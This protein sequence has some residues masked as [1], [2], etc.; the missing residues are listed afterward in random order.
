MDEEKL[1]LKNP[2]AG[3]NASLMNDDDIIRYWIKPHILFSRQALG[4][5]LTGDIPVVL[6]G[7]RGTGKTMLLKFMSNEVTVKEYVAKHQTGHRFLEKTPYLA[8]YHRFDGPS[9][10]SFVSRHTSEEAWETIF[11]HYLELVIG[12]KFTMML[13]NLKRN[14][15]F[16]LDPS[17]ENELIIGVLKLVDPDCSY[18]VTDCSIEFAT[19]F[20]Q[21]RLDRVFDFI[22]DSAISEGTKFSQH[23]VN[24]G[25]LIFGVP[26]L[27]LKVLPELCGKKIIILLDEYENLRL[28][29]QKIVNTLVKHT[30]LPVTFRIGTRLRGF[31]TYDTL[32]EGE[33]LMEDADY[34]KI[35]FEDVLTAKKDSFRDLLRMIA[36]RRLE[37]IREFGRKQIVDI[38]EILGE[39]SYED[40]ALMIVFG[41]KMSRREVDEYPEEKYRTEA[42]HIQE[43]MD[44]LKT[45]YHSDAEK[46]LSLLIDKQKPLF[47][48]LN[49]LLLRRDYKPD[50]VERLF[51][52]YVGKNKESPYYSK[53]RNLYDKNK[54]D[55]LFQL[56]SL[57]KPRQKQYAGFS[58]FC[59]L[60]SGIIRN[61]LELCYQS[62]NI[63]L[64]S[65][66]E[67]LIEGRQMP[68]QAQTEGAKIRA[69]R[70]MDVIERI[71]EYGNEVKSLVRSLGAIFYSWQNDPV[72]SEPEVTYFCVDSTSLSDK[73]R[74]IL[75]SAAQWSVLQPKKPMKGKS[76][77]D[78]LFDAY[79][80]NHILAPYFGISYRLRGR[81]REFGRADLEALM[82][83]TEE[84]KSKA[85]IRLSRHPFPGRTKTILDFV[86]KG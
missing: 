59:M 8:V 64:F 48:M 43:I 19:A 74:K 82:F 84:E 2:F 25:R 42:K 46:T 80:L 20:L 24:S 28:N 66:R 38:E 67:S 7:G 44:I 21:Q 15:C 86:G 11:K 50:Q 33:F 78:P 40:E 4:V 3:F 85:I 22:N 34:R 55:L 41:R 56:I 83:G 1:D 81:I 71:P 29:Q 17:R 69:E 5:D 60:S 14:R 47:E 37:Q 53:Y 18:Q 73:A 49:L 13:S 23:I 54:V 27:A 16:D 51:K 52:A 58:T 32:N 12:Q 68:I 10:G 75:D 65:D 39:L 57:N 36:R 26:E 63:A 62:F 70:Y 45:K 61:F 79:A 6:E 35:R 31:K 76:A 30:K 9:L 72:L 77:T